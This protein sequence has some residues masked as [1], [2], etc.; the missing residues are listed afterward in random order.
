MDLEQAQYP[1]WNFLAAYGTNSL[2]LWFPKWGSQGRQV[3]I[4][5]N[6][7]FIVF[8]IL[9]ILG[10]LLTKMKAFDLF[11]RKVLCVIRLTQLHAETRHTYTIVCFLNQSFRDNKWV[12]LQQLM[13][14][15]S[16]FQK[17]KS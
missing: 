1:Y 3:Q 16:G 7:N 11:I 17:K 2:V 14:F 13:D 10:Q 6:T 9:I 4:T 15:Y 12:M 5:L 8:Y